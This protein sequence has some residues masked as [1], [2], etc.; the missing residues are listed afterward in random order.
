[1]RARAAFG[2]S[3]GTAAARALRAGSAAGR[4]GTW[5]EVRCR[6]WTLV[7]LLSLGSRGER[8][9]GQLQV[10]VV[11]GRLAGADPARQPELVDDFDR[12]ARIVLVERHGEARAER[13]R[14]VAGDASELQRRE[15]RVDVAVDV[16]LDQLAAQARPQRRGSVECDDPSGVDD[17]DAIAETFC[18]VE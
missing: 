5:F 4:A 3:A 12:L 10:D 1:R 6:E 9:A 2:Q 7:V 15:S 14:V 13:E 11:E 17:R 18:L 16:E 8:V